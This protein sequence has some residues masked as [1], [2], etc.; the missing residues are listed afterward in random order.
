MKLKDFFPSK[1]LSSDDF[2]DGEEKILTI[3]SVEPRE[4]EDGLKPV[5]NFSETKKKL[6]S[7]VTNFNT[8]VSMH[9]DETDGWTGKAIQL[10]VT[11]VDFKGRQVRAIRVRSKAPEAVTT[12]D[13]DLEF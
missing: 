12:T 13:D 3:V 5:V 4:F 11:E 6:S 1:Y 8:I 7:N 2:E 10:F 9:G